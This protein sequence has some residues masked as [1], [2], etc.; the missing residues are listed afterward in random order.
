MMLDDMIM[1][2]HDMNILCESDDI[3]TFH[4]L[5]QLIS[6]HEVDMIPMNEESDENL[7]HEVLNVERLLMDKPLN[8]T[9]IAEDT[10]RSDS[11]YRLKAHNKFLKRMLLNHQNDSPDWS[12]GVPGSNFFS[13]HI[14]GCSCHLS[15]SGIW[16]NFEIGSQSKFSELI[17][18]LH[19]DSF[20]HE[21]SVVVT[22]K[23]TQDDNQ[24]INNLIV[25]PFNSQFA[26]ILTPDDGL[27]LFIGNSPVMRIDERSV[28]DLFEAERVLIKIQADDHI[29]LRMI[30]NIPTN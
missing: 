22:W 9:H 3:E 18:S 30:E 26:F 2:L 25:H 10:V 29:E 12:L 28:Y 14:V 17:I 6:A 27:S 7:E 13:G 8:T 4:Q 1:D 19:S 23:E 16:Q 15:L 21:P 11:T 5:G 24:K 20:E